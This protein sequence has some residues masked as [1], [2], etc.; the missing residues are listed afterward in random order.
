[1]DELPI[2][3][4]SYQSNKPAVLINYCLSTKDVI[5]EMIYFIHEIVESTFIENYLTFNGK[6]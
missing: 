4:A 6:R 2:K 5:T 3:F 1:M